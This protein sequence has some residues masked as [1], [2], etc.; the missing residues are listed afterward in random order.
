MY[1]YVSYTDTISKYADHWTSFEF[2]LKHLININSITLL[3]YIYVNKRFLLLQ[4]LINKDT[5]I[6]CSFAEIKKHL[7]YLPYFIIVSIAVYFYKKYFYGHNDSYYNTKLLIAYTTEYT[8]SLYSL[9][10]YWVSLW[11]AMDPSQ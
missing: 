8:I 6:I 2:F 7:S 3:A 9:V 4:L 1:F 11:W 10:L 5:I